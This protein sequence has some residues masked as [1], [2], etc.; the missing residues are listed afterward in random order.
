M[1]PSE[2]LHAI[3]S[4]NMATTTKIGDFIQS[5]KKFEELA[6][7]GINKVTG[8]EEVFQM[9]QQLQVLIR[10][11]QRGAFLMGLSR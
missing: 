9:D 11:A 3:K 4:L 1:L 2:Q 8:E 5:I 10:S 6:F 7:T